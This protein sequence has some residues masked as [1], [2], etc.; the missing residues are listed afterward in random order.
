MT[1][2]SVAKRVRLHK[3]L[4]PELYCRNVRCLHRTP[5]PRHE[6]ELDDRPPTYTDRRLG[7]Q[8]GTSR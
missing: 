8:Q 3:E 7:S 4:H 6:L 5:C 1:H 2:G